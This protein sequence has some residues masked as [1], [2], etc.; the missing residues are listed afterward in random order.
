MSE[1]LGEFDGLA[2]EAPNENNAEE[3]KDEAEDNEENY[4]TTGQEDYYEEA[5]DD[6]EDNDEDDEDDETDAY[7]NPFYL[8]AELLNSTKSKSDLNNLMNQ[9]DG[10]VE[11][12]VG[13]IS[14]LAPKMSQQDDAQIE[15]SSTPAFQCLEE[16][17]S[18]FN[19]SFLS[20]F[21]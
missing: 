14:A 3:N 2:P 5:E 21:F 6:D 13:V 16:V 1:H 18:H 8:P 11:E 9:D 4:N 10:L 19:L 20:L 7:Q 15:I 12:D 17:I